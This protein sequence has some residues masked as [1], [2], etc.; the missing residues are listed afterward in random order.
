MLVGSKGEVRLIA[1]GGSD[2]VRLSVI[3]FGGVAIGN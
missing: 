2:L 1:I 3:R